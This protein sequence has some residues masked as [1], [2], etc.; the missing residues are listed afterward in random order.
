ME[1]MHCIDNRP[2]PPA[3]QIVA[4]TVPLVCYVDV[5]TCCVR[6]RKVVLHMHSQYNGP[7][8]EVY[9]QVVRFLLVLKQ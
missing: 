1:R 4:A 9:L 5:D 8:I 7:K 2:C 3:A 6:I